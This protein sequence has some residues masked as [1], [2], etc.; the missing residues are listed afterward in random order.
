MDVHED[1]AEEEVAP[2]SGEDFEEPAHGEEEAEAE[3]EGVEVWDD[4]EDA[5]E[6]S[7]AAEEAE[8]EVAEE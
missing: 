7:L 2:A 6:Q 4:D 1:V 3:D 8:E 5:K